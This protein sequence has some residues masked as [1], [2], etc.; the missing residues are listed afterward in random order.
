[1]VIKLTLEQLLEDP[2]IPAIQGVTKKS[3]DFSNL[4]KTGKR[5]G[6][7]Y[8]FLDLNNEIEATPLEGLTDALSTILDSIQQQTIE[9]KQKDLRKFLKL[10]YSDYEPIANAE[11]SDIRNHVRRFMRKHLQPNGFAEEVEGKVGYYTFLTSQKRLTILNHYSLY[12]T[13]ESILTD[14]L[15]PLSYKSDNSLDM[16]SQV[17]SSYFLQK[18][19]NYL[20]ELQSE[21]SKTTQMQE[22]SVEINDSLEDNAKLT[23]DI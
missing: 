3:N 1:M 4:L 6:N 22:N 7:A 21:I 23:E 10:L 15:N 16:Q 12:N 14:E 11:E 13:I 19:I 17:E 20:R 9:F 8:Y 5:Q 18:A 2:N